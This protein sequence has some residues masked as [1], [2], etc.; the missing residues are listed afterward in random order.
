VRV[1][2]VVPRAGFFSRPVLLSSDRMN[3]RGNKVAC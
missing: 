2:V 3:N 1:V